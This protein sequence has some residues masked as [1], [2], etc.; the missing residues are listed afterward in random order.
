MTPTDPHLV[1][2]STLTFN[3]T[4]RTNTT[5]TSSN[6]SRMYFRYRKHRQQWQRVPERYYSIVSSSTLMLRYPNISR[7]FD[8]AQFACYVDND[9]FVD[10]MEIDVDG[11]LSK[12]TLLNS[13]TLCD[14]RYVFLER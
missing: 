3:C 5:L 2:G 9:T 13:T 1:A 11:K 4:L 6:S 7:S 12:Q 14:I 10:Q 8:R